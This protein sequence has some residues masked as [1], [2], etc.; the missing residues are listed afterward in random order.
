MARTDCT[1]RLPW[2][3]QPARS[4]AARNRLLVS[5]LVWLKSRS[6]ASPLGWLREIVVA[7]FGAGAFDA[8]A[9]VHPDGP[10]SNAPGLDCHR[11][12]RAHSGCEFPAGAADDR[13]S[14]VLPAFDPGP[15]EF[16]GVCCVVAD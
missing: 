13:V 8:A 1:V 3:R 12:A 14:G 7:A 4:M 10:V 5:A 2:S 9:A 15:P 6:Q 11:G 16:V